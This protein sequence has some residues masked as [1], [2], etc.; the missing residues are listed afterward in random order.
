M[1]ADPRSNDA[2]EIIRGLTGLPG[3]ISVQVI[4]KKFP[5][6]GP[7]EPGT[8]YMQEERSFELDRLPDAL[9]IPTAM[10]EIVIT[11][12]GALDDAEETIGLLSRVSGLLS[13][14]HTS[15]CWESRTFFGDA[16]ERPRRYQVE[17]F[18]DDFVFPPD[19]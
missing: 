8:G 4:A 1:N 12:Q 9:P 7:A 10:D 16:R 18:H 5:R 14:A 6:M 2:A 11:M 17:L 19:A 3:A 13:T 15:V